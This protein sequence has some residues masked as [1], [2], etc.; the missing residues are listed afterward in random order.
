VRELE[1]QIA[2]LL[3]ERLAMNRDTK[4]VRAPRE[5]GRLSPLAT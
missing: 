1:R 3:F 5:T 4:Q 2:S